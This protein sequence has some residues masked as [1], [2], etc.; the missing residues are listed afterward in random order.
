MLVVTTDIVGDGGSVVVGV[1]GS[2]PP[3]LSSP[4][5]I[6][7]DLIAPVPLISIHLLTK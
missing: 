5:T 2:T 3:L 6:N 4:V 1:D 7:G